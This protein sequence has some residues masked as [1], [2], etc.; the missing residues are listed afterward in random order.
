MTAQ[1]FVRRAFSHNLILGVNCPR[2]TIAT[3]SVLLPERPTQ[4]LRVYT[5]QSHWIINQCII[6]ANYPLVVRGPEWEPA[7]L[8]ECVCRCGSCGS[9]DTT[10][11][12]AVEYVLYT[13]GPAFDARSRRRCLVQTPPDSV[14]FTSEML[15][16][17][18][19]AH[20][21]T[22]HSPK[23][24]S[25]AEHSTNTKRLLTNSSYTSIHGFLPLSIVLVLFNRQSN[26]GLT[27][28]Q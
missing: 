21:F 1:R 24:A 20:T 5:R 19:L 3:V 23:T 12:A 2:T 10:I 9:I 27:T 11:T 13:C 25:T 14:L 16:M 8:R 26:N 22:R 15:L 18:R 6:N 4:R 17:H 28:C 7:C